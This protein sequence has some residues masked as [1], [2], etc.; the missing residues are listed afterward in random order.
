MAH[1]PDGILSLPVLIGG[2]LVA[3]GGVAAGLRGL[4][5]RAIPRVAILSGAFFA[6]SALAVPVGPTSVHLMLS[7]LMGVMLG[8]GAAPAVLV[9]LMLQL[10]FFGFG[11][12]T[13]LGV[14]VVNIAGPGVVLGLIAGPAIR[15][16]APRRAAAMAAL[17]AAGA[18]L[19]TG[20]LVAASIWLSAPE[21]TPV[22][23]VLALTYLPLALAEAAI[24]A[25]VVGF[26]ARVEPAA[27]GRRLAAP[28]D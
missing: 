15:A 12:L 20:A 25:A 28:Q 24:A 10:A 3:A 14:N 11:G 16:A 27:L 6:A 17:V 2:A 22:A 18:A 1:I 4:E 5:D 8:W 13:T 21:F 23:R 9:G 7:G 19:G 26:L